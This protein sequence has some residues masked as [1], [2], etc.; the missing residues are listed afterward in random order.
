MK[1]VLLALVLYVAEALIVD[2]AE[3]LAEDGAEILRR[4]VLI[5]T[6]AEF[7]N[8]HVAPIREVEGG[9]VAVRGVLRGVC[10]ALSESG[11]IG[12][13][14]QDGSYYKFVGIETVGSQ[15][16]LEIPA[17]KVQ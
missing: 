9:T 16:I 7:L 4:D 6:A 12:L 3:N 10:V 11:Y 15:G 2:I 13:R 17:D 14:A 8:L 1:A 5:R